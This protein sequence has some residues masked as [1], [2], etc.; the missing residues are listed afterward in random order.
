MPDN[1]LYVGP[2]LCNVEIKKII[3]V[4]KIISWVQQKTQK[5]EVDD[6]MLH[7]NWSISTLIITLLEN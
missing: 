4:V 6:S 1:V 5:L 2:G 7:D 3:S